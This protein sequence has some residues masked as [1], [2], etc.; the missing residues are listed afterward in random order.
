VPAVLFV[1]RRFIQEDAV[2]VRI[3]VV[4]CVEVINDVLLDVGE[5][6]VLAAWVARKVRPTL[7]VI[8]SHAKLIQRPWS[9]SDVKEASTTPL[10]N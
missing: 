4:P 10:R 1:G 7:A 9:A 6:G 3:Q 5:V 2:D 8:Q